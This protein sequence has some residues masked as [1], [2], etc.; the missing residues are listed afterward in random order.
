MRVILGLYWDNGKYNGNFNVGFRVW[1]PGSSLRRCSCNRAGRL[2][3][4]R[5]SLSTLWAVTVGLGFGVW[6]AGSRV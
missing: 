6:S 1:G 4:Q 3:S 5:F 2:D